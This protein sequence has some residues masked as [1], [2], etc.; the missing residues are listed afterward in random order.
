ME[1]LWEPFARDHGLGGVDAESPAMGNIDARPI[2][3]D[4]NGDA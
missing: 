3:H 1:A 2:D 4:V